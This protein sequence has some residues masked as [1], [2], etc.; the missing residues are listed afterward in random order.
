MERR[1][2]Y[3]FIRVDLTQGFK[4]SSRVS[5][6]SSPYRSNKGF[7]KRCGMRVSDGSRLRAFLGPT[8]KVRHGA[9]RSL[10]AHPI[11]QVD[12]LSDPCLL[13][14]RQSGFP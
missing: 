2:E 12:Y 1:E 11:V 8:S 10:V 3:V 9:E 4:G 13:G 6:F 7:V 5:R 14:R